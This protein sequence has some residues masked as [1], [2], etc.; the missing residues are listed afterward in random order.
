MV[1]VKKQNVRDAILQ[2]AFELFAEKD[3]ASTSVSEIARRAG[4]SPSNVYVYF[5]SKLAIL[6]A[7]LR[8]WLF[9]QIELLELELQGIEN[10]RKRIEHILTALWGDIPTRDNNL[11]INLIQGIALSTPSDR[12]SRDLL[13]FLEQRLTAMLREALPPARHDLLGKDD[14]FAHLA[15]MAFDGFVIGTRVKGRSA[16]LDEAVRVTADMLMGETAQD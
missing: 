6:W 3:Y 9:R 15:F 5:P 13:L 10:P 8:P 1:Q 7:V 2:A 11:A 12:Y 16:R 4:A 14:A